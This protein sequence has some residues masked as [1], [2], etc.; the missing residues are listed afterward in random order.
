MNELERSK[1]NISVPEDRKDHHEKVLCLCRAFDSLIGNIDRSQQ[2]LCYTDDWRVILIDHS[3]GFRWKRF[4]VDQLI[5]GQKGMRKK[6]YVPLPRWFVENVKALNRENIRK[7]VGKYLKG[8]EIDGI[9][10]RKKLMLKEIQ[11]MIKDRGEEHV[12]Y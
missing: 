4:Y 2:N 5:Y 6:D 7:A 10:Q 11:S 12:L 1:Q 3:R 9:L 8:V